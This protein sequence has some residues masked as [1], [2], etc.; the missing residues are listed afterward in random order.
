MMDRTVLFVSHK[1][2]QCGVYIPSLYIT[3][4]LRD[5]KRYRFI[6]VECGA[7]DELRTAVMTHRPV[8]I[9]CNYMPILFPWMADGFYRSEPIFAGIVHIGVI[10][11]VTRGVAA[12]VVA[13]KDGFVS[14]ASPSTTTLFDYYIAL[15]PTIGVMSPI[16]QGIGRLI[17][18]YQN[19]FPLPDKIT[20]GSFGFGTPGKGFERIV[21]LVEQEF[22]EAVIRI[23][24]PA[25]TFCD[26]DGSVAKTIAAYCH[27]QVTKPGIEL[28]ITHHYW[29]NKDLLDFLAQHTVNVFLY[30]DMGVRGISSVIDMALA[31]KRPMAISDSVMYRHVLDANPS[32]CVLKNDPGSN[33]MQTSL[34]TVIDNGFAPLQGHYDKW[35]AENYV[36]SYE[37]IVDAALQTN[38]E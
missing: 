26:V 22:D 9:I 6:R 27:T 11:D 29:S 16:V 25:S 14:G 2:S 12:G 24:I 33:V 13:Y 32:I 19:D 1:K 20:V 34:R 8:A 37:G 30:E 18:V 36:R 31:V 5:S 38:R 4:A 7:L 28:T 15:D 3:A 17:P 23:N 35:N 21:P 10:H